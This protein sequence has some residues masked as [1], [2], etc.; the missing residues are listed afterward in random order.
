MTIKTKQTELARAAIKAKRAERAARA[1]ADVLKKA[2]TAA[3]EALL[4]HLLET[5]VETVKV[6]GV[7]WTVG[8]KEICET[9]DWDKYWAW[10]RKDT[11][12]VYVQRRPAV[13]ALKELFADGKTVP[14]VRGGQVKALYV[15]GL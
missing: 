7:Q 12:G 3:E 9:Y 5:K 6:G 13:T 2:A 4:A 10:A 8:D 14:G 15:S 1:K 11:L